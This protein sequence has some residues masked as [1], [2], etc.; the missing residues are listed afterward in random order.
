VYSFKKG[1]NG[2]HVVEPSAYERAPS[3]LAR[4][5]LGLMETGYRFLRRQ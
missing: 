2:R 3:F 4:T 1:L 5:A